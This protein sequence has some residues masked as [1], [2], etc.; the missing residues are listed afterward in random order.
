MATGIFE[1]ACQRLQGKYELLILGITVGVVILVTI[2]INLVSKIDVVYTHLFYIPI[3]LAAIFYHR[4]AVYL[5]LFLGVFHIASQ[6]FRCRL[7]HIRGCFKG[8][9]VPDNS[10][11]HRL[12]R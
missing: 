11:Y 3:I 1:N 10:L 8:D 7:L 12:D 5:A 9:H 2:Y 4:K 6:L